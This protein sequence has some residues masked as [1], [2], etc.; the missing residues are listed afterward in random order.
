MNFGSKPFIRHV[1][2]LDSWDEDK[3]LLYTYAIGTITGVDKKIFEVYGRKRLD[4]HLKMVNKVGENHYALK[5]ANNFEMWAKK[6][7]LLQVVKYMPKSV[8]IQA[9]ARV[10][11]MHDADETLTIEEAANILDGGYAP[12]GEILPPEKQAE[13]EHGDAWE[14]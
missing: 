1:P 9:A 3:E 7:P 10:E 8:E 2:D 11:V 4:A 5:N 6:V 14:G 13:P 12:E